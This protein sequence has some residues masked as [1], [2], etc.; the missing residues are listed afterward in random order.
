MTRAVAFE[1]SYKYNNEKCNLHLHSAPTA[2]LLRPATTCPLSFLP[3]SPSLVTPDGEPLW[4]AIF[5]YFHRFPIGCW[6]GIWLGHSTTRLYLDLWLHVQCLLSCWKTNLKTPHKLWASNWW[7]TCSTSDMKLCSS[8]PVI[9][10]GC[11]CSITPAYHINSSELPCAASPG[12]D[13]YHQSAPDVIRGVS[14][15]G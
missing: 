8:D 9:Y 14:G 7:N 4:A 5:K 6:S 1:I 15:R 11:L 10:S 13:D 12:R 3:N 2:S